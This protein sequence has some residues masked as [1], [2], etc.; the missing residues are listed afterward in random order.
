MSADEALSYARAYKYVVDHL[1]ASSDLSERMQQLY[2]QLLE[3][4][5]SNSYSH[6][7]QSFMTHQDGGDSRVW[8]HFNYSFMQSGVN[9]KFLQLQ[10]NTERCFD[11]VGEYSP[12]RI[13]YNRGCNCLMASIAMRYTIKWMYGNIKDRGK[14]VQNVQKHINIL[15]ARNRPPSQLVYRSRVRGT[16][17]ICSEQ[18]EHQFIDQDLT[19]Y[20]LQY[21]LRLTLLITTLLSLI[22]SIRNPPT[23]LSEMLY[24]FKIISWSGLVGTCIVILNTGLLEAYCWLIDCIVDFILVLF[25]L[26]LCEY[27][28]LI[29]V[30]RP[31]SK[32]FNNVGCL[33]WGCCQS[34]R[35]GIGVKKND[36]QA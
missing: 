16:V 26:K 13:C 25:G 23:D 11:V 19:P 27:T 7:R 5:N 31:L 1:T 6:D 20:Y 12:Y 24:A 32:V 21:F 30:L 15:D 8:G 22:F 36:L 17:F 18:C 35:I 9:F 14:Y 3:Y 33:Q 29:I 2:I 28:P 4:D 10:A 34:V